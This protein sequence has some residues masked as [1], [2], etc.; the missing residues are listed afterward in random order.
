MSTFF[1]PSIAS[2]VPILAAKLH[3][4]WQK[5][6]LL[7]FLLLHDEK[8]PNYFVIRE[9]KCIFAEKFKNKG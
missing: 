9:E 2:D 1:S 7:F 4:Y 8:F 5:T 6:K 3:K